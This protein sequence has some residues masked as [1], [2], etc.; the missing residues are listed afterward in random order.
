MFQRL[1]RR[2]VA[3]DYSE[4]EAQDLRALLENAPGVSRVESI[5]R[6]GKGG[7]SVVFELA[8]ESVEAFI[9]ALDAADWMS[10]L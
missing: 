5:G 2:S 10:V 7:Y 9:L 3:N 6:H 8:R 4:Q 1:M